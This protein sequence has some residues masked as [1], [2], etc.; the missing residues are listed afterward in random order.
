MSIV[1]C[2]FVIQNASV[3]LLADTVILL[4]DTCSAVINP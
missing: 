2:M 4:P 1:L 3:A